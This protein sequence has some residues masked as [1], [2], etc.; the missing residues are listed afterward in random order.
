M[1]L[2][3][4]L[5]FQAAILQVI[6]G[7][8]VKFK[9]QSWSQKVLAFF[10]YPFNPQYMTSFITTL[11]YTVYFPTQASYESNPRSSFTVLAHELVHM[12][13]T[14]KSPVSFRLSYILPQA[15]GPVFLLAWTW[16]ARLNAWPLLMIIVGMTVACALARI[17]QGAFWAMAAAALIGASVFVIH[18]TGWFSILFFVG[19]ALLAP[20]PSPW[21]TH[22][23]MRGY[24]MSLAV[25]TWLVGT[26]P[27]IYKN[28]TAKYFTGSDYY[29]MAWAGQS[30]SA[31]IDAAVTSASNGTLLSDPT[32]D[33]VYHFLFKNK[34]LSQKPSRT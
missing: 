12:A 21:R 18:L 30:V 31:Q 3:T 11:G 6:P 29:F 33:F 13:D 10:A 8:Q 19:L 23:E 34:L 24:T 7:F 15:L 1:D 16:F 17:T 32:F 14:K 28:A 9:D 5:A 27:Q 2:A 26:P 20:W 4:L 25:Y 22:W